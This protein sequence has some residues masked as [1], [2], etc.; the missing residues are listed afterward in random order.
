MAQD[1][2]EWLSIHTILKTLR[3]PWP[4]ILIWNNISM[5]TEV[6]NSGNIWVINTQHYYTWPKIFQ[7]SVRGIHPVNNVRLYQINYDSKPKGPTPIGN[8]ALTSRIKGHQVKIMSGIDNCV[9]W[10]VLYA[11]LFYYVDLD[12]WSLTLHLIMGYS[13]TRPVYL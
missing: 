1:L 10:K 4:L 5:I 3:W 6:L 7:F 11:F 13:R 9:F 12:L 8:L 2:Y